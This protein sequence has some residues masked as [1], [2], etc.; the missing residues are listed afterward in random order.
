MGRTP[1]KK[2]GELPSGNVR[3]QVYDYTD[4][5]GKRH[6]K[7][8]TGAT[9]K[10]AQEKANRWKILRDSQE[11]QEEDITVS[12]A[13][14]RYIEIKSA[15]LSPAT[16]REYLATEKRYFADSIGKKH[17]SEVKSASIQIWISNLTR[18]GLSA[19]TVRNAY[20]LLS[21]TLD[22]FAPDLKIKITLP[23]RKKPEL[24]CPNDEDIK[25]LLESIKGT[26]LELAV[27]LAAFGPLRRG[28]ICALESTDIKGNIV[29]ISKSKV[30]G[31]E[32]AW[33]IKQPKTYGSYREIEFPDFVMQK[34]A[35][36]KGAI[37]HVTPDRLSNM[38]RKAL[39]K[40]GLPHFRFHDLRHYAASIMHAI[41]VPD[42]Y[43]LQRGGWTSEGVMRSVYRNVIDLENIR[44]TQKIN[45]HF[46]DMQHEMQ[47]DANKAL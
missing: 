3:V 28:E 8:F 18:Q 4:S 40:T 12:E 17:L 7:S 10:E 15:V 20:G 34:L 46:S 27:L 41:G 22:M 24:Y 6:Y 13:V 31:P 47:H 42:Q 21:A 9:R 26:E 16:H 36:R 39:L 33:C 43:I 32:G 30:R 37:I 23:Q 5:Q 45:K 44:Q 29:S 25:K 35:G 38:F 14:A 1:K 2:K 11:K 19:K